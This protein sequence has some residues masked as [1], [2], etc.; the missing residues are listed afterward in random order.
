MLQ[1]VV[2]AE[3]RSRKAQ[4]SLIGPLAGFSREMSVWVRPCAKKHCKNKGLGR[5][6]V[7]VGLCSR[8]GGNTWSVNFRKFFSLV[9]K[10]ISFSP[11]FTGR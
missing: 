4:L 10:K 5:C 6:G 2:W 9:E 7:P 3:R 8:C 1:I 11:K